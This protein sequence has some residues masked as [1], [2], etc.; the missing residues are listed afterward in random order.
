MELD[1]N[2]SLN[3]RYLIDEYVKH[4]TDDFLLTG[5]G[6]INFVVPYKYAA[7]SRTPKEAIKKFHE[8]LFDFQKKEI[9]KYRDAGVEPQT[10]TVD[11]IDIV[12]PK[13]SLLSKEQVLQNFVKKAE[14]KY[15]MAV[16]MHRALTMLMAENKLTDFSAA[17]IERYAHNLNVMGEG[18]L[19]NSHADD[20]LKIYHF[21]QKAGLKGAKEIKKHAG[22]F[23]KRLQ[24]IMDSNEFSSLK[25]RSPK[26]WKAAL[27]SVVLATAAYQG[28]H[29]IYE[30]T[31]ETLS[32]TADKESLK[33]GV[34]TDFLNNEHPDSLGNLQ[35]MKT[36]MPEITALILSIEG[37]AEDAFLEGGKR[38]TVGS[39]FTYHVDENG[40]MTSVQ[41]GD[42]TNNEDNATQI[43][44]YLDVHFCK[45][46]GDSCG[47]QLSERE[48][49]AC[50][51]AG[52]CWGTDGFMKSSFFAS[53]LE[54]EDIKS[55]QRKLTG[56]RTPVGLV[57]REY[58]LA[59][60][61][62]GEWNVKD[63][64]DMPIYLIK[65]KGYLHCGIYPPDFH[66]YLP[67]KKDKKGNYILDEHD[68]ELPVIDDDGFCLSFYDDSDK[69]VLTGIINQAKNGKASYKTVRDFLS[70]DMCE[71]IEHK[72]TIEE[73]TASYTDFAMR[74]FKHQSN[75]L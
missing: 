56:F 67:C 15:N 7:S 49:L 64:L 34:Y 57:K 24:K 40:D 43:K 44:R 12:I 75:S 1:E 69:N 22:R 72:E 20:M 32:Q 27:L 66:N 6:D 30:Q 3:D 42:K 13:G 58:L 10:M 17:A 33:E 46:L 65:G 36:L 18:V 29:Y 26:K 9:K 35:R 5:I 45:L 48:I 73:A 28:G 25:K 41:M 14:E 74:V 50:I 19:F 23:S 38:P 31:K 37:Y 60:M 61:L 11:G 52:F 63:L 8:A 4:G 59:K 53:V 51:G 55:Q 47:K 68:N 21:I 62:S 16:N 39:G 2:F 70:E 54:G 71:A